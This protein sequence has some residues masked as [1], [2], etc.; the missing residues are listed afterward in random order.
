ME[1]TTKKWEKKEKQKVK[2]DKLKSIGKQ[3]IYLFL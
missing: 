3:S 1:P 2:T